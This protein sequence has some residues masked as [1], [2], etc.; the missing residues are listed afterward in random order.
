VVSA[1]AGCVLH[2]SELQTWPVKEVTLCALLADLCLTD[3]TAAAEVA[4][5]A[6]PGA[7]PPDS[8][9][10]LRFGCPS[11]VDSVYLVLKEHSPTPSPNGSSSSA[12]LPP[13]PSSCRPPS[14]R[15]KIEDYRI[16]RYE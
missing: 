14:V 5:V 12:R 13:Y 15:E 16:V 1:V 8:V 10:S 7:T 9:H 4:A 2:K 3:V 11:V 6:H